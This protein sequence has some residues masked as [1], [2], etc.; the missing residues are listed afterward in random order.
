MSRYEDWAQSME[1]KALKILEKRPR[2]GLQL[3]HKPAMGDWSAVT[4]S[5]DRNKKIK[6]FR[7]TWKRRFDLDPDNF[8]RAFWAYRYFGGNPLVTYH[9]FDCG[10]G[11]LDLYEAA[12]KT[13]LPL[14]PESKAWGIDGVVY[15]L[16]IG[17]S[18]SGVNLRWWWK[19]PEKWAGL[20]PLVDH[21]LLASEIRE[22]PEVRP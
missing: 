14:D 6:A 18:Y 22:L 20:K 3:I 9:T 13:P 8:V 4:V 21:L 2:R 17:E 16:W 7:K 5:F 1:R 11:F 12:A 10:E 15:E 19:L